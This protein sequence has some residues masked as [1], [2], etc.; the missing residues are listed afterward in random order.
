MSPRM[1]AMAFRIWQ[2]A[3]PRGWDCTVGEIAAA[4]EMQPSPIGRVCAMRGWHT[5]LRKT[6]LDFYA[7][8]RWRSPEQ[9]G[10]GLLISDELFGGFP[11]DV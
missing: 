5:R 2:Y 9:L 3:N 7:W 6:G 10:T 8:G 11:C 4:L 1:E